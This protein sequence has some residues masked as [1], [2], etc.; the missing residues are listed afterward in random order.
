MTLCALIAILTATQISER[1]IFLLE[2]AIV[3][4]Q[5]I[6][7]GITLPEMLELERNGVRRRAAFKTRDIEIPNQLVTVGR[8]QQH[9]LRDSWKFEVAA[10]EL[11]KLLGVGMVPVTVVRSIDDH[12]GAVIDWVDGVLPAFETSPEGFRLDEWEDE[13]ATIWVFDYLA[14]NIDRTPDNLLITEGFEVRLIDHSRAFQRFVVPMRPLVR[15]PKRV[16]D[17]LR[18]LGADDFR[19]ALGEY[20]TREELEALLERRKRVLERVD[21]LLSKRA[22]SEVLF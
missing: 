4:Q 7:T 15:F 1:E 14:Y 5:V 6:E 9:G 10:Y 18:I 11:D 22:E 17:A 16:I 12:Q 8:E 13:V 2:A 19:S 21:E 20:L 3:G